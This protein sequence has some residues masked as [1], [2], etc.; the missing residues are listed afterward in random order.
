MARVRFVGRRSR[1]EP[2]QPTTEALH[3]ARW[4]LSI[5]LSSLN[6]LW[7]VFSAARMWQEFTAAELLLITAS[8]VLL[9]VAVVTRSDRTLPLVVVSYAALILCVFIGPEGQSPW[10]AMPNLVGNAAYIA[11]MLLPVRWG[12]LMAP[13]AAV[14]FAVIWQVDASDVV[15]WVPTDAL[16]WIAVLQVAW[17]CVA[18]SWTWRRMVADARSGDTDY[19]PLMDRTRLSVAARQSHE[20]WRAAA[21][22]LHESV[23]NTIRYVL[24][25]PVLDRPALASLMSKGESAPLPRAPQQ[26]LSLGGAVS[27]AI[28]RAGL[29]SDVRTDVDVVDAYLDPDVFEVL[30]DV[31]VELLRNSSEHGRAKSI[32]ISATMGAER[33]MVAEVADDGVGIPSG[34]TAGF[35]ISGV[36]EEG[37][38]RIGAEWTWVPGVRGACLRIT[39]P[40][41]SNAAGMI[42]HRSQFDYARIAVSAV[43]AG[44]MTIGVLWFLLVVRTAGPT[45]STAALC[46]LVATVA[47]ILVLIRHRRIS[48]WSTLG[49]AALASMYPLLMALSL[50]G[51]TDANIA[52]AAFNI[53]GYATVVVA[54]W[55]HRWPAVA[56]VV[57]WA[58]AGGFLIVGLDAGCRTPFILAETNSIV[59]VPVL[60]IASHFAAKA[61]RRAQEKTFQAELVEGAEA[62]RAQTTRLFAERLDSAVN[63]G[64]RVLGAIAEGSVGESEGKSALVM[65]DSRIRMLMQVEP[66]R[67]GAMTLLAGNVIDA[68]LRSGATVNVRSLAGS[69]DRSPLPASLGPVLCALVTHEAN[70]ELVVQVFSDGTSDYLSITL[71][72][73]PDRIR[74]DLQE[75]VRGSRLTVDVVTPEPDMSAVMIARPVSDR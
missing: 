70:T 27:A 23:L 12:W 37:L 1:V 66:D 39:V 34:A 67:A 31:F 47:S 43:L 73:V 48:A 28:Q 40:L 72:R 55:S 63:E 5:V 21:V 8:V 42:L 33:T 17:A 10:L 35:G 69:T 20:S 68:A 46:G 65:V 38:T 26:R 53:S 52:A 71:Q 4:W 9:L 30:Q 6:I 61:L 57:M 14:L 7:S 18:L 44:Q 29:P 19:Q 64:R 51:C 36:V 50:H 60:I 15:M 32:R 16:G 75:A 45:A 25:A 74:R 49:V 22:R 59:T 41:A 2:S 58:C 56:A 3:S 54:I 11:I 13:A 62:A 24:T